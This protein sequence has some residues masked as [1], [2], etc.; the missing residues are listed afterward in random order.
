MDMTLAA[1]L[2]FIESYEKWRLSMR[3]LKV[4]AHVS[5]ILLCTTLLLGLL[6]F[7]GLPARGGGGAAGATMNGDVNCDGQVNI[8]DAIGIIQWQFLGATA[9][10]ALA[11]EA[12]VLD[13]LNALG[14]QITAVQ[15][16]V[17][18]LVPPKPEDLLNLIGSSSP[19]PSK[20]QG[21]V[22]TV[23]DGKVFVVTSIRFGGNLVN[24]LM[25]NGQETDSFLNTSNGPGIGG[26]LVYIS[27]SGLPLSSGSTIGFRNDDNPGNNLTV[28]YMITGYLR[29][30]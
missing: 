18:M 8:A 29:N 16:S 2:S 23:P 6:S 15:N 11:Q 28:H 20:N 17:A 25:I 24:S 26:G 9:P 10:C 13:K 4:S 19:I 21:V 7:R 27:S 30:S 22:Y 14:E 1:L 3:F 5:V 12:G